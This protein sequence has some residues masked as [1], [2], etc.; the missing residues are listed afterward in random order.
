MR[1]TQ[2]RA[3]ISVVVLA[4]VAAFAYGGSTASSGTK[5]A[6]PVSPPARSTAGTSAVLKLN[7]AGLKQ[8]P[9][10]KTL[11]L[12]PW[13]M[14]NQF[15]NTDNYNT[16]QPAVQH[17]REVGNKTVYEALAYTN[18][19]TGRV[20]PW[21]AESWSTSKNFRQIT[22]HLRGG[23][24]WSD[25]KPFTADDV[26]YTLEML[27]DNSPDL[28]YSTIYKEWLRDVVVV[29]PLTAVIRLTKPGPRFFRDNLALGWENH[30][31]ILPAHIWKGQ[32]PKTFKNLDIEKGWPVGTG[33]YKLVRLTS[34]QQIYDRR[35]DY[36]GSRIGFTSLP[37]PVRVILVPVSTDQA[38]AQL[39]IS[40]QVDTGNPLLLA[41]WQAARAQNPNLK[42]WATKGPVWGAPDSCGYVLF[43]NNLKA[44]WN[45]AN[46]RLAVNYSLDRKK[47]SQ[48][49]Y[50]GANPSMVVPF[51]G[52]M[53]SA[54]SKT[55]L[56]K[57]IKSFDRD[58]Q[59]FAL[60]AKYMA[61][62]GYS[63]DAS[64]HWAKDGKVLEVPVVVPSFFSPYAAPVGAQ[65]R[66]AGFDA[67]ES[68]DSGGQWASNLMAGQFDGLIGLVHCGSIVEPF[69]TLKDMHSKQSRPAGERCPYIIACS[70][71]QNPAMD[72]IL[73]QME[74]IPGS[75]DDPKYMALAEAATKIYL[76]D[77]PEIMLLEELH[78]VVFNNTY[79]T[80]W[81]SAKN[82]YVAPYPP[83][84]G[85]NLAMHTIKPVKK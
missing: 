13:G 11:I 45:D 30:Q 63:K 76:R 55:N 75:P 34:T 21:L 5:P 23:V 42:S 81:P 25:G 14:M 52:Y 28:T 37:A 74:K 82:P 85:F 35:S 83:W 15:T 36:W 54:Y 69:D 53:N 39:L 68:L 64:G 26:K 78:V 67:T 8:V 51:S 80:G 29:N 20:I 46:L 40:N 18:M 2:R 19:N 6:A 17:I 71:Y 57:I 61:A 38:H 41:T 27:R 7:L 84:M 56:P 4:A 65:L 59:D 43:F 32:D 16:Y 66:A 47:I 72:K 22:V 49:G 48:L 24:K 44:P 9:R 62:A 58:K 1:R 70:H 77:M 3:A 12:T 50:G 73:D 79:W 10:T 33:A 31:I 60:V